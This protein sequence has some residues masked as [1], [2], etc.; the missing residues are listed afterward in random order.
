MS[1][2]EPANESPNV[3]I[4]PDPETGEFVEVRELLHADAGD[5]SADRVSVEQSTAGTIT[6][7]SVTIEQSA[8][9]S[10]KAGE[11]RMDQAAAALITSDDMAMHE[12]AAAGVRARRIDLYGSTV[13]VVSGPVTVA[14]GASS[15]IFIQIGGGENRPQ[16]ILNGESA[17]RLGAGLGLSLVVFS[18]FLR[19]LLG[20]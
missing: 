5:V 13:G 6:A 4:Q 15:R 14:E 20:N 17:L 10:I 2:E 18:R 1:H 11:I 3:T 8:V 12:S 19:R 16:P 9:K 7:D